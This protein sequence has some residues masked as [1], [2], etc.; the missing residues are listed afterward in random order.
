MQGL[1]VCD[2]RIEKL[3][4]EANRLKVLYTKKKDEYNSLSNTNEVLKRNLYKQELDV[5][6]LKEGLLRANYM[7]KFVEDSFILSKEQLLKSDYYKQF[8]GRPDFY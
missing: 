6:D 1:N 7:L 3:S 5:S 8:E 4:F 2:F